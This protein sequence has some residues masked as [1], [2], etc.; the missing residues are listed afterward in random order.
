[1]ND[2]TD[3]TKSIA[4]DEGYLY[5]VQP[6]KFLGMNVFKAGRA[7]KPE[8]RFGPYGKKV[9]IIEIV[10]VKDVKAGERKVDKCY[11]K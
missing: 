8:Q 4:K 5:L 2:I 10:K 9:K 11:K 6:E 1:M 3:H 7:W